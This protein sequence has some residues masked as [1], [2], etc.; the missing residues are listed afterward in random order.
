MSK[1]WIIE[2]LT[3]LR[4]FA[5]VNDLPTLAAQLEDALVVAV[6]EI[7]PDGPVPAQA[8]TY[9]AQAGRFAGTAAGRQD[10]ARA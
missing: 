3:D 6:A 10:P 9:G 5:S 4:G 8:D 2:V 7:G 1:N